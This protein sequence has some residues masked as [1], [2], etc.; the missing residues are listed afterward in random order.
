VGRR[1]EVEEKKRGAAPALFVSITDNMAQTRGGEQ[2]FTDDKGETNSHSLGS[3]SDLGKK[4]MSKLRRWEG[5]GDPGRKRK[6]VGLSWPELHTKSAAILTH[7]P[8]YEEKGE[9][10]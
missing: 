3:T 7:V 8:Q 2:E 4:K 6:A 1:E 5:R 10:Y 9:K